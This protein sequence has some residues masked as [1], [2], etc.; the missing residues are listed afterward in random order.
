MPENDAVIIRPSVRGPLGSVALLAPAAA[1][2][3]FCL[4]PALHRADDLPEKRYA[5]IAAWPPLCRCS[6]RHSRISRMRS[7]LVS[8]GR[9]SLTFAINSVVITAA[10][11]IVALRAGRHGRVRPRPLP[12]P[13]FAR[14]R[15]LH[16]VDTLR[17]GGRLRHPGVCH[18]PKSRASRYLGFTHLDHHLHCGKHPLRDLA[19]ARLLRGD[20]AR[21]RRGRAGRRGYSHFPN[22]L[23][24]G[25]AAAPPGD[26][27]DGDP[28]RR[29]LVE[30]SSSTR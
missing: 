9:S 2:V 28:D 30:T 8:G 15:L 27:H 13:R 24:R 25:C 16:P 21:D 5:Q 12:L 7:S 1:F 20:P 14:C 18:R 19:A 23:A 11:T 29:L 10:S 4:F 22:R 6:S 3:G 26:H 17:A